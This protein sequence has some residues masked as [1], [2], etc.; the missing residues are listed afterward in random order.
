MI[1]NYLIH[2]RLKTTGICRLRTEDRAGSCQQTDRE[3]TKHYITAL[4]IVGYFFVDT[5]E[6]GEGG[7]ALV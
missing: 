1:T 7:N 4:I 3:K 5:A 6:T 2:Y